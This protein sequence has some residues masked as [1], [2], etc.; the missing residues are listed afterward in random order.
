MQ[1]AAAGVAEKQ[2]LDLHA[3]GPA[4]HPEI[5]LGVP[6]DYPPLNFTDRTG[7]PAGL[8]ADLIQELNARLNGT[9]RLQ[10]G[11]LHELLAQVRAGKLDGLMDV[12]PGAGLDG[13]L[14]FTRP[15]LDVP[16]V[17]VAKRDARFY[18][19]AQMLAGS[20]LAVEKGSAMAHWF[21]G[22][23]P[24]VRLRFYED[25]RAAMDGVARGEAVAYAGNR[26]VVLYLL[27]RE[28]LSNMH[29]QGRL[30]DA[31]AA[32]CIGIRKESPELAALL[33]HGLGEVLRAEGRALR[34]KWYVLASRAGGRFDPDAAARAWLQVHPVLRVGLPD[35]A[36]PM[37]FVDETGEPRGIAMDLID[38]LNER[39]DGRL[40]VV[41]GARSG[42]EADLRAGRLDALM[43][44]PVRA[45]PGE[46]LLF[47]KPYANIP[48]VIVGRK[49]GDQHVMLESLSN[50]TAAVAAGL[51]AMSHLLRHRP[52]IRVAGY[53]TV[54]EALAAVSAG[55]AEA[56]VGNRAVATWALARELL[57]DLRI[58][59]TAWEIESVVAIGVR[60]DAPPLVAL[61]DA[62]LA[63][64]PT[65]AV[66]SIYERWGGE[67][68]HRTT[69][70][71]WIQLSPPERKW[72]EE[73][74]VIRVGSNP[75]WAPLEF[76]D[77]TGVFKG[78]ASDY[79]ERFGRALGVTFRQVPIPSWRQAHA[80]LRE[81]EVDLLTSLNKASARRVDIEFTPPYQSLPVAVFTHENSPPVSQLTELRGRKVAVLAGYGMDLL[82]ARQALRPRVGGRV[83][84][85][86]RVEHAG[87]G[88]G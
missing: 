88:R 80:K 66:Q 72:L 58:Q 31:P 28:M 23:H 32:L 63:S 74:P 73:H 75:R 10:A 69:E 22:N 68:W 5:R 70:L 26:A 60:P 76:T 9:I 24:K 29:M 13:L 45:G 7:A 64:L 85:A 79:L 50:R 59:G 27:E 18:R 4:A 71:S 3:D 83:R 43:D 11:P 52:G 15:Y 48:N 78:I 20:T 81:G 55:Q 19:T 62:A 49:S 67:D 87:I 35:S 40:E 14:D 30:D 41:A 86:H 51:P 6:A 54:R 16:A 36:P 38:L 8:G 37:A 82:P 12:T 33:D 47:T 39:L 84:H 57:A 1:V 46:A 42:L 53:A 44:M 25:A 21:Q 61:L 65:E 34:A 56:F 77:H 17:I 2:A